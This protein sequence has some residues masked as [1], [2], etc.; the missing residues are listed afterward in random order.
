VLI[1]LTGRSKPVPHAF[2]AMKFL[3]RSQKT[4]TRIWRIKHLLLLLLRMLLIG[5]LAFTFARPHFSWGV[6]QMAA[7][8]GKLKGDFVLVLDASLSMN[9]RT[10]EGSA[11][12]RAQAQA[13]RFLELL[14][15][16]SRAAAFLAAEEPLAL[17]S[18]LTLD[19][20]LV[21]N[22][23]ARSKPTSRGLDLAHVLPAMSR[24]LEQEKPNERT[25]VIVFF[26][27]L[28]Q[29]AWLQAPPPP[30]ERAPRL[31]VVDC[32]AA[33]AR[34]GGILSA[35]V[36]NPIAP[37]AQPLTL[38]VRVRALD[39]QRAFPIDL[40]LDGS[41]IA[42]QSV[43]PRGAPEVDAQFTFPSGAA[44]PHEGR[45]EL[46]QADGL[47]QD[48]VRYFTYL[49]GN[50]Q[51]ALIV[52]RASQPNKA[53]LAPKP[54]GYYLR[55]ALGTQAA[56][57]ASGFAVESCATKDLDAARLNGFQLVILADP[58]LLTEAQWTAL[59]HFTEEGGGLMVW[60]G[61]GTDPGSYQQHGYSEF[62]KF[63]GLLPGKLGNF[64]RPGKDQFYTPKVQRP[65]HALFERFPQDVLNGV[66]Q[67]RVY[68]HWNVAVDPKDVGTAV[69]LG[70][71]APTAA[72]GL[73][74]T[75]W[76][77]EKTYG[78]GRV[79][80]IASGPMTSEQNFPLQGELFVSLLLEASRFLS[81]SAEM[82]EG[83]LGR[84]V[85]LQIS[86]PPYKLTNK[87]LKMGVVQYAP[88]D[89]NEE[90]YFEPSLRRAAEK[91][92]VDS[93]PRFAELLTP[94]L[95]QPGVHRFSW[96]PGRSEDAPARAVFIAV[97]PVATE[98]NLARATPDEVK[99]VLAVW[100]PE[101]VKD[102]YET[103]FTGVELPEVGR[104]QSGMLLLM[105][106]LFVLAECYFASRMQKKAV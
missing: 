75:P 57:S 105:L 31:V 30:G 72:A 37:T 20:G 56:R 7:L 85:T 38:N 88:P 82:V 43:D 28:Q 99:K 32:G 46:P 96:K 49:A 2:P 48:S 77:L 4:S 34:N 61:E 51:R 102:V 95:D 52:E 90:Q 47:Q 22:A 13:R 78:Q 55:A 45:V 41:K 106:L 101:C 40:Y 87:V 104:E 69:I 16:E 76:L 68:A 27:D 103:S 84:S 80:L 24:V 21:A 86:D 17:Q 74:D 9:A 44:G 60:L 81:G 29:N 26:T 15:P 65:D 79:L 89:Q 18:R 50:P 92:G 42:Q 94:P 73:G 70:L 23:I 12:E 39:P 36:P 66:K 71:S 19:H 62:A 5:W 6:P 10:P 11:Y 100:K 59:S 58:G 53:V 64:A 83:R 14:A 98:S 35:R 91:A 67:V 97:N 1:H 54:T 93:G 8:K 3:A 33:T 63:H 25:R